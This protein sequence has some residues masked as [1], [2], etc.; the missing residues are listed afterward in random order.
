MT[1]R[2][3]R[4]ERIGQEKGIGSCASTVRVNPATPRSS[5]MP[6]F[7]T[8]GRGLAHGIPPYCLSTGAYHSG[9]GVSH[10]LRAVAIGVHGNS[11]DHPAAEHAP[12]QA[13]AR[14][15]TLYRSHPQTLLRRV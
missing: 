3:I 8:S 15:Q 6:S 13:L 11:S 9:M 1:T 7:T 4:T 12:A 5:I 2:L 14:L 10:A